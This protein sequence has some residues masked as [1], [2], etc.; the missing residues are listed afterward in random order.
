MALADGEQPRFYIFPSKR[1]LHSRWDQVIR[2]DKPTGSIAVAALNA[3]WVIIRII[4]LICK[5]VSGMIQTERAYKNAKW[6]RHAWQSN[7]VV[8]VELG[9]S[10][11]F[12]RSSVWASQP[13]VRFVW[14]DVSMW[15]SAGRSSGGYPAIGLYWRAPRSHWGVAVASQ[16]SN[17][18]DTA[19][20]TLETHQIVAPTLSVFG[21]KQTSREPL[22]LQCHALFPK[23]RAARFLTHA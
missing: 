5:L 3:G 10:Q 17:E 21:V 13:L 16:K 19:L 7:N 8:A 20:V 12:L 1:K 6:L 15:G 23:R 4:P 18:I 11:C 2:M 9:G 14:P 22:R